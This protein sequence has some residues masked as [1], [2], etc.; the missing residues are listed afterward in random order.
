MHSNQQNKV[1]RLA[2][3]LL[4]IVI[5]EMILLSDQIQQVNA[6]KKKLSLRKVKKIL[7]LLAF[8]KSKKKFLFVPVSSGRIE[9]KSQK[10]QSTTL[11]DQFVF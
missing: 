11:T 7:P 3:V 6:F 9:L 2:L 8:M 1:N 4:S 5:L 10:P